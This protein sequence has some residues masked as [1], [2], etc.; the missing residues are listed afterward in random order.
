MTPV[1]P[2]ILFLVG[3]GLVE[4]SV[5]ASTA[6][7]LGGTAYCPGN[8]QVRNEWEQRITLLCQTL[9]R[10]SEAGGW[11]RTVVSTSHCCTD[12]STEPHKIVFN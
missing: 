8:L 3:E 9:Q 4:E 5:K 10:P 12:C 11:G 6:L 1:L 2:E 7:S